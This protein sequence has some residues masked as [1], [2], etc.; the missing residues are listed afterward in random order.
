M[1]P[2]WTS[3]LRD[4]QDLRDAVSTLLYSAY[5]LFSNGLTITDNFYGYYQELAV[6]N[7][8]EVNTALRQGFI[9]REVQAV[10]AINSDGTAAFTP[11]I[12]W[13]VSGGKLYVTAA[14][15]TAPVGTPTVTLRVL[16]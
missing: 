14:Y 1:K 13:Y 16:G 12:K 10:K 7:N 5:M 11:A 6:G 9:P 4:G 8:N 15:A 2:A 3:R